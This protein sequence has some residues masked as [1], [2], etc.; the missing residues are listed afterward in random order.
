MCRGRP[1]RLPGALRGWFLH[2]FSPLAPSLYVAL[3]TSTV[4]APLAPFGRSCFTSTWTEPC[5][6]SA[7]PVSDG[8]PVGGGN[9]T[10]GGHRVAHV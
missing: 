10:G 7:C 2:S 3:C 5:S 6:E 1:D 9:G 4:C 8:I